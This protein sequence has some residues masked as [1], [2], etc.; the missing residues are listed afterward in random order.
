MSLFQ[1]D[2]C[3]SQELACSRYQ[4]IVIVKKFSVLFSKWTDYVRNSGRRLTE[5]SRTE[6][7][8]DSY[9]NRK[10]KTENSFWFGLHV[11]GINKGVVKYVA[12][13]PTYNL[14]FL[15]NRTT[16]NH[17]CSPFLVGAFSLKEKSPTIT[18][19][20]FFFFFS[21]QSHSEW[22]TFLTIFVHL[23]N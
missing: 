14:A 10:P 13:I 8:T 4:N 16:N 2:F 11:L 20:S 15:R 3:F 17:C 7:R 5:P 21:L 22:F 6:N 9:M 18:V 19:G 23:F 12:Y 1:G